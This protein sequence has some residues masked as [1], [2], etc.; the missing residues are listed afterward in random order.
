MRDKSCQYKR[1]GQ[2]GGGMLEIR[3]L[4]LGGGF[5]PT[6]PRRH[7]AHVTDNQL[8]SN[9][10]GRRKKTKTNKQTNTKTKTITNNMSQ[11]I[12]QPQLK[13]VEE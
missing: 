11:T 5:S 3:G 9:Q 13:L 12:N 1:P 4:G 2:A 6:Y 7:A 10:A 8:T